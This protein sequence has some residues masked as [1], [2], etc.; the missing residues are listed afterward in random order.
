MGLCTPSTAITQTETAEGRE[1]QRTLAAADADADAAA[2]LSV[3]AVTA[4][5]V[6]VS[7]LDATVVILSRRRP[8]SRP[9]RAPVGFPPQ[10]DRGCGPAL[11]AL[12]VRFA[13]AYAR[14][15]RGPW[16][17]RS[18]L[19]LLYPFQHRLAVLQ[20][21]GELAGLDLGGGR[22]LLKLA[23]HILTLDGLGLKPLQLS[24]QCL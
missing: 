16:P 6:A 3:A 21:L 20:P 19:G 23:K 24:Q 10:R 4:A 2:P 5:R 13:R 15:G 22:V 18:F 11:R 17:S 8:R 9:R 1:Q 14:R 7:A 12:R